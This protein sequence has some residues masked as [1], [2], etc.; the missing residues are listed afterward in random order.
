MQCIFIYNAD[1]CK[2]AVGKWYCKLFAEE[3]FIIYCCSVL[4]AAAQV[5]LMAVSTRSTYI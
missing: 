5:N 1:E 2:I 3:S 4:M